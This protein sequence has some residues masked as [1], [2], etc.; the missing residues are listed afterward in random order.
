MPEGKI[1]HNLTRADMDFVRG[2]EPDEVMEVGAAFL[3]AV[4][5]AASLG[6]NSPNGMMEY[7]ARPE[8][9]TPQA[10]V[11]DAFAA[12]RLEPWAREASDR[13]WKYAGQRGLLDAI[14]A[15]VV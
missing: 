12:T 1:N 3:M 4:G 7:V 10:I 13:V 15:A 2:M 9:G 14:A 6:H 11:W 5:L 8:D